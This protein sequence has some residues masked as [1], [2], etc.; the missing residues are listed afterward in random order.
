M[1]TVTENIDLPAGMNPQAVVVTLELVGEGGDPVREAYWQGGSTTVAGFYQFSMT[2]SATWSESLVGNDDLLPAGTVYRRT[3]TGREIPSTYE[4]GTVPTSGGPYRWDQILTDAP[5]T[6]TDS[7]LSA[8]ESD[9]DLHGGGQLLAYAGI[10]SNFTTT[11]V[12]PTD[13][14]G[15]SITFTVPDR[16][17]VVEC[18][19]LVLIEEGIQ[20]QVAV[21]SGVRASTGL[22]TLTT[23]VAHGWVGGRLVNVTV[24]D[25]TYNGSYQI[26]TVPTTTSLTYTQSGLGTDAAAGTGVVGPVGTPGAAASL[27]LALSDNTQLGVD[28]QRAET[29]NDQKFLNRR[30]V[31]P[32]WFHAPTAGSSVT[33]KVRANSSVTT[34]DVTLVTA[35]FSNDAPYIQAYT[36]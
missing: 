34:S 9:A 2:G 6:L 3:I 16:P 1:T 12:T 32:N 30:V 23:A 10:S 35:L 24:A 22:V 19:A 5:G 29:S 28:G 21:S 7:A 25:S 14:T 4:Y 33:Y 13:V 20:G 26:A 17:Y 8:H 11:S 18:G 27:T 15:L 31:V 36:L